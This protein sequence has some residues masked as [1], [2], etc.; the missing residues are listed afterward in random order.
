MT[1][2]V[3]LQAVNLTRRVDGKTLL[4]DITL[5]LATGARLGLV[6]PTGSG[7]SLLLRSL[8]LLEP[9]DSGDLLWQQ[10]PVANDQATIY[11]SQVIYVHQRAAAFEGTVETVLR[12]PFQLK[13]HRDR[14][15]D[16]EW[17]VDQL[18]TVARDA[19]FLDQAHEQLSGGE[20]QIVAL[21]RAIQLSPRVLLLDEPTSAL[22]R[23][24]ARHVESIVMRWY[25]DSPDSRAYIWV[26]HD[27]SQA[28]RVCDSLISMH[29]GQIQSR[30]TA[31]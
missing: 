25:D 30:R 9:V 8:A 29:A 19:A 21:L 12:Q 18:A 16:R 27:P 23:Q 11:R 17:I 31:P 28:D 5:D 20:A 24:S 6:G 7:K 3:L 26:S 2:D 10:A 13:A 14:H 15:F 22:D 4:D 1:A